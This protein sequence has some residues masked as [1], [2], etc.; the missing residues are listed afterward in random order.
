MVP[1]EIGA[2][3]EPFLGGG[4]LFFALLP[5][6]GVLSDLN[7]QLVEVY[8]SLRDEPLAVIAALEQWH[9]EE[10]T[11]YSVRNSNYEDRVYRS[12]QLIYLNRTCW[13]GLYRVNRSGRFNVPFG[14][15]GRQVFEAGHLLDISLALQTTQLR[16]GDFFTAVQDA[17]RGDLVYFD[18][19]YT[20]RH[21]QNGFLQYNRNLFSW[22]DQ[23]R[24]GQTAVELAERGCHVVV[25]NASYDPILAFYPGFQYETVSRSSVLAANPIYRDVTTEFLIYSEHIPR[26]SDNNV[27]GERK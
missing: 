22:E 23:E 4:S 11:Y 6:R 5:E 16:Y 12:A 21:S 3:Y 14:H 7:E 2:Y 24:L 18:P 13:N 20:T 17:K 19:P 8:E 9:N 1:D 25:T 26:M 10:E 15:H 27:I